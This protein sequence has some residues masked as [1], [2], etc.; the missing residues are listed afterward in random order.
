MS[1]QKIPGVPYAAAPSAA[2]AAA[3]LS[4]PPRLIVIHDTGNPDSTKEQEASYAHTRPVKGATSA[5]A[6]VDN[7]GVLGSL[8]LDRQAWAAYSYANAHGW[9]IEMCLRGDRAVTHAITA[10]LVA[11]LCQIAA[12]PAV[13]LTPSQVA[14]GQRGVCGHRDI[15]IGLGVGDHTDPGTDFPWPQF[16]AMVNEGIGGPDMAALE[17][18]NRDFIALWTLTSA[19]RDGNDTI[20]SGPVK[21]APVWTVQT[22][23]RIEATLKVIATKVDISPEELAAIEAAAAKGAEA[24]STAAVDDIVAGVLAGLPEGVALSPDDVEAALREVLD[25]AHLNIE[26]ASSDPVL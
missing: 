16:M 25:G 7:G 17:D 10:R 3:T 8:L 26:P 22:L 2:S 19:L 20:T 5:H 18:T 12:I 24:G 21:G 15:T 11:Q 4:W 6:Y 14:A 9:H 13:K 1:I 23:K